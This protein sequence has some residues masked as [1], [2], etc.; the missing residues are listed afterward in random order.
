MKKK[1]S[2]SLY[3]PNHDIE[4]PIRKVRNDEFDINYL[5]HD[6]RSLT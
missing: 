2:T 1:Y 4:H 6:T 3:L 5:K